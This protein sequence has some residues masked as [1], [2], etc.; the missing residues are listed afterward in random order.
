[1]SLIHVLD[2]LATFVFAL[3]GARVAADKGLDYGGIAFVA[4]IA[5]VSGGT[6]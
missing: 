5:S 1:M 4:A 2:L 6:L 3:V